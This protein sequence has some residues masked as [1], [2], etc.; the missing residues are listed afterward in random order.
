MILNMARCRTDDGSDVKRGAVIKDNN[1]TLITEINEVLRIWAVYYKEVL[2]GT[3]AASCLELPSSVMR[4]V[5]VEE[6]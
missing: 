4:E 1:G 3:G 2:N 5:D 6:I